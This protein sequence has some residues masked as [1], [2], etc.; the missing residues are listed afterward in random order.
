MF[1]TAKPSLRLPF[2]LSF[3]LLFISSLNAVRTVHICPGVGPSAEAGSTYHGLHI[4][5]KLTPFPTRPQLSIS[6]FFGLFLALV[7]DDPRSPS[8][9][10]T[11]ILGSTICSRDQGSLVRNSILK[12]GSGPLYG[13]SQRQELE[14]HSPFPPCLG[15]ASRLRDWSV[16]PT[17]PRRQVALHRHPSDNFWRGREKEPGR[18]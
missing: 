11:P 8:T 3:L 7:K 13:P 18:R 15:Q 2:R 4:Y 5:R 9:F 12:A 10:S 14:A 17:P 1:F 6:S 16:D